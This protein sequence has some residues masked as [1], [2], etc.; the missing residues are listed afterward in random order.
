MK[1]LRNLTLA[2]LLCLSP[3]AV[4]V[5]FTGCA[6]QTQEAKS[7]NSFR[8]TWTVTHTA[9]QAYCERV[10]QGK[11]TAEQERV[12]DLA[13]NEFRARFRAALVTASANWSAPAP[14]AIKTLATTTTATLK[15]H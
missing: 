6:P 10:A 14:T 5:T 3:V 4:T 8:D 15:S 11:V 12:A 7:F 13:W 9:Y 2:L 1:T